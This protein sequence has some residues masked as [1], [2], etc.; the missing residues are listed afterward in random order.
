MKI[1]SAL[2]IFFPNEKEAWLLTGEHHPERSLRKFEAAGAN[3]VALK[4]GPRGAALLWDGAIV[5]VEPTPVTP[6]DTIGAG[7]SFDA[8]FLHF[9]LR[10]ESP[11]TCLRAASLCGALST[12]GRGGIEGFPDA[13]RV[14]RELQL[15]S[16]E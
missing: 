12:E 14:E 2:D 16:N 1:V 11:L 13:K 6:L 10:G 7:D 8:G 3:R 9:W 5:Q 4:L 15:K